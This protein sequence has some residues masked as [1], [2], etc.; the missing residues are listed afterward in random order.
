MSLTAVRE[1]L[2]RLALTYEEQPSGRH[3]R[4]RILTA[5]GW[6]SYFCSRNGKG[7]GCM[8]DNA[9]ASLRRFLRAHGSG[10][11]LDGATGD[12]LKPAKKRRGRHGQQEDHQG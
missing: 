6:R 2:G 5:D 9:R 10:D 4:F 11:C 12:K 1:E 8:D 3:M 7:H